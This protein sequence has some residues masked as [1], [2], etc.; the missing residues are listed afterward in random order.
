[1]QRFKFGGI[2][3]KVALVALGGF[4]ATIAT[5]KL[6]EGMIQGIC[7]I[8]VLAATVLIV[9]WILDYA[10]KHP[11]SATLEGAEIIVWQQQQMMAVAKGMESPPQTIPIPDPSRP[12]ITQISEG[13]DDQERQ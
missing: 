9:K 4:A 13:S 3:G 5:A 8:G 2:V 10:D 11:E 6:T 7:V 1:M 12:V